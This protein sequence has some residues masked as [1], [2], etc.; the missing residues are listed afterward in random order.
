MFAAGVLI[1]S[2]A[3]LPIRERIEEQEI[4]ISPESDKEGI[5]PSGGN[6]SS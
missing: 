3:F 1:A 6:R 4:A 2:V 5:S